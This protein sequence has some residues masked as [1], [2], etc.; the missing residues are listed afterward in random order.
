MVSGKAANVARLLGCLLLTG[1]LLVAAARVARANEDTDRRSGGVVR[2]DDG[3]L[4]APEL[5]RIIRR[6]ELVAAVIGLPAPPFVD[7]KGG[8]LVGYDI[9]LASA[10][11]ATLRVGVRF[12]RS[13][14]TYNQ[15]TEMVAQGRADIGL[16]KLARTLARAQMVRFSHTYLHIPHALLFNR[17]ALAKISGD[18]PVPAMV[19]NFSG[20][21]GVIQQSAFEDF[22]VTN[23]PAA[24]LVRFRN[25]DA[26]VEAVKRGTVAAI[27]RDEV[28]VR[29]VLQEDAGL[30]LTLRS[31]TFTDL[32]SALAIAVNMRDGPL[33]AYIN[34]FLDS[35]P[36]KPTVASILERNRK[37]AGR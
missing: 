14:M 3:R 23:F 36:N 35:M 8:R 27:Y 6:G 30:A 10:I 28:E 7:E 18:R 21:L 25:W 29:G 20:T 34:E 37:E 15:V 24:K 12:D 26:A 2:L 32:E 17:V 9:E 31:V 11:A 22:A 33:L 16:S 13:A 1:I 19:R 5:A 4:V